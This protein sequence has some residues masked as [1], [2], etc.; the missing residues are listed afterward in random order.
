MSCVE[1]GRDFAADEARIQAED[2]GRLLCTGC[3]DGLIEFAQEYGDVGA[4]V[5]WPQALLGGFA[6][7]ALGTAV[8]VGVPNLG[9]MHPLLALCVG[10]AVGQGVLSGNGRRRAR[11]L[12][13]LAAGIAGLMY[14]VGSQFAPGTGLPSGQ[15]IM[16]LLGAVVVYE[17]WVIPKPE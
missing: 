3:Y 13:V 1:C 2:D 9:T 8:W 10:L 14:L 17:A 5:L 4:T 11:T 16:F 6:G 15:P 7:G 12:Q